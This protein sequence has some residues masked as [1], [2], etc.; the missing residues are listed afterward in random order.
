M[1]P[2][3]TKEIPTPS[4]LS[5][6]SESNTPTVPPSPHS[7]IQEHHIDFLLEEEFSC[8]PGFLGF[9]LE[10]AKKN[11]QTAWDGAEHTLLL[12]PSASWNCQAIR[13]VTTEEGETDVL[14][15]Y[16][17]LHVA[18]PR[19]A[20]LIEDKIRAGF[21]DHQPERYRR[22]GKSGKN[23]Y[24]DFFFTC[25]VSPEKSSTGY[26]DFDTRV[27][28]EKLGEFFSV[29]YNRSGFRAGVIKRALEHYAATGVQIINP[30]MTTFRAFYAHEAESFFTA[31]E[32]EWEKPR[33][34]W[35]DD[36][37]FRFKGGSISAPLDIFHKAKQGTV[38]LRFPY[39]NV[40]SLKQVLEHCSHDFEIIAKQTG[41]SASVC[42]P[43]KPIPISDFTDQAAA[44]PIVLQAFQYVRDLVHFCQENVERFAAL[45]PD[46]ST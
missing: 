6:T 34:A 18:A 1:F 15:T 26:A 11:M 36:S 39:T 21:Q 38:E 42:I 24:W 20:I 33:D 35:W 17:S 44:K 46:R 28:L 23:S 27:S 19:V 31:G 7:P 37:W 22:R 40:A 29:E 12:H 14:V 32:I 8:N 2:P 9:F 30:A 5:E 10:E 45:K 3:E 25:L 4:E 16:H 13:S 43:L 41:K